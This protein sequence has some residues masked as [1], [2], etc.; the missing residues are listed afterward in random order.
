M[1]GTFVGGRGSDRWGR[2]VV[3]VVSLLLVPAAVALFYFG[4]VSLLVIGYGVAVFCI[5]T[6]DIVIRAISAELFPTS[7]RGTA[8]G[9]LICVQTL[10]WV[11]AL[12]TIGFATRLGVG[13]PTAIVAVSLAAAVASFCFLLVPETGARELEE[14]S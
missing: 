14:I 6:A 5:L 3:G 10:G 8:S 13:L 4:P 12:F 1:F 7:H 2:R 11:V 9:W